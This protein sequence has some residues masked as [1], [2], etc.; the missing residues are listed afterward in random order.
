LFHAVRI[1]MRPDIKSKQLL[2]NIKHYLGIQSIQNIVTVKV[3]YFQTSDTRCIEQLVQTLIEPLNHNYAL[4]QPLVTNA[5]YMIEVGY[6]PGV[7]NPEIASLHKMTHDL[8]LPAIP[9][10]DTSHEYHFYG[11]PTKDEMD[12]I[13]RRLL[14]NET[15]EQVIVQKVLPIPYTSSSKSVISIP[16]HTLSDTQLME[17]SKNNMLFLSLDEMKEIQNYFMN[18]QRDPQDAEI[19]TIAQTWS[20]HCSHKTF[21]SPL[22]VNGINKKSLFSRLKKTASQYNDN[23]VSAFIDNAGAFLFYDNY[24]L[25]AKVET[26][27]SPSAIEPYGGASTGSGGVFR[28]IMG[29]GKG[30]HVIASTDIFCFAPPHLSDKEIPPGCLHP[31]YLLRRVV[32][33]VCDYGNRMGIPTLNGSVHFHK[34][35]CAKPTIIVG[36]YG[37]APL[38]SSVKQ[39]PHLNDRIILVGGRTGRDGIHGAT[40][41][42]G[43]MTSK[44]ISLNA[45][46]VQIGNAIE[47][48]RMA[49]ALITAR[50]HTLVRT[51]TDC[52]AGG[53]S[54]AIGEIGSQLGVQVNLEKVPL[55]Y[56][57]LA[58]WEIWLSESQERMICVVA[59]ENVESFCQICADYNVPTTD[60]GFFTGD[61]RLRVFY[62]EE[63]VCN[64][65]MSFLHEGC[66]QKIMHAQKCEKKDIPTHAPVAQPTTLQEWENILGTVL[67]HVNTCSKEPIVRQYDHM[68]Q[69]MNSLPPYIGIR[70]HGAQDAAIIT[71]LLDQPYAA[72]IAHGINPLLNNFDPY[73]GSLWAI[74]ECI[75]NVVSVGG[76]PHDL[77]L[78]DNFI[79]PTPDAHFL[80]ALDQ[81]IQ[82]CIDAMN[83]FKIPFISGK[84]SLSSTYV[85]PN[86]EVLTIPPVLCISAIGKIPD[87]H[88]TVSSDLKKIG[89]QLVLV[90]SL[91]LDG[92]AGS[93]YYDVLALQPDQQGQIPHV[94]LSSSLSVFETIHQAINDGHILSCHDISEGGLAT[95][96]T[97]MCFGGMI[98]ASIDCTDI[99]SRL[100]HVLFNETAGCFIVEVSPH[101][102][103]DTLFKGVPFHYLG[104]TIAEQILKIH[105]NEKKMLS[106]PL[107][108]LLAQWQLPMKEIFNS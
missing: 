80:W 89:S 22:C 6:K 35:F 19:E 1:S 38:D 90:G 36:A 72:I 69:G 33:G 70:G 87:V 73:Y 12:D 96:V 95:T 59:P 21:K 53:L 14:V 75:A 108:M 85:Y 42:S 27:N 40:F 47:Q 66:P 23:I 3:Y 97:E 26:H 65:A 30:A 16:I 28:D 62:N 77:A 9:T 31:R 7:M 5:S 20:E 104:T 107:E 34:D 37:I 45:S 18:E 86:G 88:K 103:L 54:S 48:K 64:V 82:A 57:G 76:N 44:T 29:T 17:L 55:K 10:I 39:V 11:T 41:S 92:M 32:A 106:F 93:V 24:A 46:A 100:D 15:I 56:K 4:N 58:P 49:D 101:V 52:G 2:Y 84:D 98:G 67:S 79:W 60:I 61:H 105:F 68:V 81:A 63:T 25:M 94:N 8:L 83:T 91:D 99:G 13:T 102:C 71:P 51:L 78:L 50:D 43:S 74:I